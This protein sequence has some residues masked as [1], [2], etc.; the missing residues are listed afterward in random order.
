[1]VHPRY[2]EGRL[3]IAEY[4]QYTYCNVLM[5][6]TPNSLGIWSQQTGY[7]MASCF[8]FFTSHGIETRLKDL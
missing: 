2:N 3:Y 7:K 4:A 6:F 8:G 1:M 5:V